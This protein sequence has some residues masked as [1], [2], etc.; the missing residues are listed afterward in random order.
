MKI[1]AHLLIRENVLSKDND[2]HATGILSIPWEQTDQHPKLEAIK[3]AMHPE[4]IKIC[5]Q[6]GR[7]DLAVDYGYDSA[8]KYGRG[9]W[10]DDI[11]I[12]VEKLSD[13]QKEAIVSWLQG[14][15]GIHVQNDAELQ[16]RLNETQTRYHI[17]MDMT[18]AGAT[19]E[20]C[21]EFIQLSIDDNDSYGFVRSL[22]DR[23]IIS[24]DMI[25]AEQLE[26][27]LDGYYDNVA[28]KMRDAWPS[29][30]KHI[31]GNEKEGEGK[32][33]FFTGFNARGFIDV[34]SGPYITL[35]PAQNDL[36]HYN[37]KGIGLDGDG[38]VIP[39]SR[40][41]EETRLDNDSSL[42]T[43]HLAFSTTLNDKEAIAAIDRMS[44]IVE[45][46]P[47]PRYSQEE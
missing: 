23:N 14:Q 22:K 26:E 13:E 15:Y 33:I 44:E 12:D 34:R 24:S 2:P 28:L 38:N 3:D 46:F 40:I 10:I 18:M 5:Q 36:S 37:E 6:R 19:R 17:A 8:L 35:C 1:Q 42:S 41:F 16:D 45:K 21:K 9:L 25:T 43:P 47:L 11:N 31:S 39:A 30:K 7:L 29:S 27:I 32:I 4:D 20:K